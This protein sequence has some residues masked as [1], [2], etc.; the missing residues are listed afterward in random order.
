MSAPI[1]PPTRIWRELV[2]CGAMLAFEL[3]PTVRVTAPTDVAADLRAA[4]A[5]RV[6]AMRSD[7]RAR[8]QQGEL[9]VTPR[10][11][12]DLVLPLAPRRV[13]RGYQTQ[14]WGGEKWVELSAQRPV[15]GL[16]GSCG[17]NY[18]GTGDCPLCNAARI[19]ALRALG[20]LGAPVVYVPP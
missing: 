17:E 19:S 5:W 20:R 4:L 6:E 8:E 7:L 2:D 1:R 18:G 10:A 13:W 3:G 15:A 9:R 14:S 16:C 11:R 12:P